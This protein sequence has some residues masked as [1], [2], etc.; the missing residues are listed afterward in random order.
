[1]KTG[2]AFPSVFLDSDRNDLWWQVPPA[3]EPDAATPLYALSSMRGSRSPVAPV[4]DTSSCLR[5]NGR[6]VIVFTVD[7]QQ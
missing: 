2:T 1:M 3:W 4:S 5:V 7:Q 6:F